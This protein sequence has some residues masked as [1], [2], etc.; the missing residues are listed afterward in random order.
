MQSW[1]WKNLPDAP[2]RGMQKQ[3][4]QH[5]LA[6]IPRLHQ[7][8]S[9]TLRLCVCRNQQACTLWRARTARRVLLH[10][11]AEVHRQQQEGWQE[12][13]AW[14]HWKETLLLKAIEGWRQVS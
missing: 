11:A 8:A 13:L 14:S 12:Q 5:D 4:L 10:W 1:A 9:R 3:N 2:S 7:R 6:I